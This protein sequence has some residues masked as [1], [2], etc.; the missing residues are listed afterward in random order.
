M[1]A[2]S[3]HANTVAWYENDGQQNFTEHTID[4]WCDGA[5]F[6][7]P[8]DLDADGDIDAVSASQ[9]D[10]TVAWYRNDGNQSFVKIVLDDTADGARA[11]YVAD[12][13]ADD[14]LSVL[15][16]CPV[17]DLSPRCR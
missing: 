14:R 12:L 3:V 7:L 10:D 1:V 6:V 17:V 5:Y 13:D 9:Y 2:T 11:V 8:A 4:P 16:S 15:D